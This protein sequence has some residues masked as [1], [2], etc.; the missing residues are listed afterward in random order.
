MQICAVN[1]GLQILH[2]PILSLHAFIVSASTALHGSNFE[3]QH[4]QPLN[5]V[6]MTLIWI[7]ILIQLSKMRIHAYIHEHLCSFRYK[8]VR[9]VWYRYLF[10]LD[11]IL[12]SCY[13]DHVFTDR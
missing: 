6:A 1:T 5:Y 4:Q 13:L 2:S 11:G 7:L 10:K 3:P 8:S 12:T 9:Y